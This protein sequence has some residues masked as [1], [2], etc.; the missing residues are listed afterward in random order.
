MRGITKNHEKQSS[1]DS[2]RVFS[3]LS[4]SVLSLSLLVVFIFS[5][6]L[7]S[8]SVSAYSASITTASSITVDITPSTTSNTSAVIKTEDINV[9][10][11]CR[12]GYNLTI[13][14]PSDR[15]LY[16]NGNSS[17]NTSGQYFSP[18]DG[19]STLIN[20]PNS[21]GYSLIANTESGIF[22]ALTNTEA[23]LKT[24]TQ[25]AS[26]S[27]I[28]DDFSIY[29]GVAMSN[30]MN[31]GSYTFSNSGTI[32]YQ[33]TTDSNCNGYTI[34]FDSNGGTGTMN[35]QNIRIEETTKIESNSFTAPAKGESYQDADGITITA[36]PN[37]LWAFWGWNTEVDG[38]GDWYKNGEEITDIA[39]D[40]ETI[41]LY[42]QW[43]Q[44]TLSDMAVTTS[45]TK[46]ITNNTMQDISPAIC[47]NSDIT[48]FSN[49]PAT[50]LTDNRDGVVK[51]YDVS[52]LADSNCWMTTN[53]ALGLDNDTVLLNSDNTDLEDGNTFILPAS[54][55]TD[56]TTSIVNA[57]R[58]TN[59]SGATSNGTYYS[60]GAA[61]T[62]NNYRSDTP[63]DSICPKNWDLPTNDQFKTLSSAS[64]YSSSYTNYTTRKPSSF[65][66]TGG[67]TLGATFYQVN[68]GHYW[69]ATSSSM[70]QAYG[71]KLSSS[72]L[73]TSQES[74]T[75]YGGNKFYRKNVR[76][77][78][79]QGRITINYDGN[80]S[81][82]RPVT[83]SMAKQENVEIS[84]TPVSNNSYERSGYQFKN[85][86]TERDGS[87]ID[88]DEG[89]LLSSVGLYDGQE[90]TLYAQWNPVYTITYVNN[91][92][93]FDSSGCDESTSDETFTQSIVMTDDPSTGTETGVLEA[94]NKWTSLTNKKIGSWNTSADGTGTDYIV[95][96]TFTVPSGSTFGDGIV[97]YAQ[98]VTTYT[99]VFDDNGADNGS[100]G[101]RND[102]GYTVKLTNVGEND[103][104]QLI[105]SNYYR[106]GYGFA[107]WSFYSS[108]TVGG[109]YT[110]YGPNA[111]IVTPNSTTLSALDNNN[112]GIIPLYA[113]WVPTVGTMQ[114]WSGCSNMSIG[115]VTALSDARDNDVYTIGKLVDGNCWMMENLRLDSADS[116]D[117]TLSQG[118]SGVFTG[119]ANSESFSTPSTTPNSLYTTDV[120]ATSMNIVIGGDQ[121]YRIPRYTTNSNTVSISYT[122]SYINSV[123]PFD[124]NNALPY[125]QMYL[126]GNKYNRAAI[127][128][129]TSENRTTSGAVSSSIC[130]SGW[131]LP[132]GGNTGDG[133]LSGGFYDL[134]YRLNNNVDISSAVAS[135]N[136]RA[137]PNNFV[138]TGASG[139]GA[140]GILYPEGTYW[141]STRRNTYSNYYFLITNNVIRHD[142]TGRSSEGHR[143]R[144]IK[145]TGLEIKLELNDGTNRIGGRVYGEAGSTVTLPTMS[146]D[147]YRFVDWNTA[148]DG[149][150]ISYA[151]AFIFD[152]SA[153]SGVTLYAQWTPI[154]TIQYDGNGADAGT[155]TNVRHTNTY[156]GDTFDLY[157]SNFSK[158]D[159]GFAGWS[160][161]SNAQPGGYSRIYG[162]NEEIEAPAASIPGEVK[163]LYA[164]WVP[165]AGN[166]QGWQGCPNM[167]IGDVTALKDMR[168]NNVYTVGKL[169]DEN[170]WMMENLR[171]NNTATGNSDG[172]LAQGYGGVFV[173]LAD[174]ETSNF[175]N[176]T[177]ANTLYSTDN[178]TG[179]NYRGYRFPRYNNANT[180]A[181][182][183][184]PSATDNRATATSSH[185]T[186]LSTFIYSYG[187]YYTW[188]AALANT[189][190]YNNPT[191][192]IDGKTS[193]TVNTSLCPSGWRLPY[194]RATGNGS[195]SGGFYYLN[196]KINNDSNVTNEVASRKIRTFPN[197]F[198]Y[199]GHI[200]SGSTSTKGSKGFYWSSTSGSGSSPYDLFFS[201]SSVSPGTYYDSKYYGNSIRCI[202]ES[203]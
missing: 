175:S 68:S 14:G 71:A 163:T 198:L 95:S 139:S 147:N 195:T 105:T 101:M 28:D 45:G 76:C 182:A 193:E 38:T 20:S 106:A 102:S 19:T 86:N 99:I 126:I 51:P 121:A 172:S 57:I 72:A 37:K 40:G 165:S 29:Y 91:C 80:G 66:A 96:S 116:G 134:N 174:P 17:N 111:D 140:T 52:K 8:S 82:L 125:I 3:N 12:A 146:R 161:D 152:A 144:C 137:Y 35:E 115:E 191:D 39:N 13:S 110:I 202:V 179:G 100:A 6:F 97:L 94:S 85:W 18:V 138:Y 50:T 47:Y 158:T 108:A 43:K 127:T 197:N 65:L 88:V 154:Y 181:R 132:Y 141:S 61:T 10:T 201:N 107:G 135:S 149:S 79:S 69:S 129:D 16:K 81:V 67:F 75:T 120:S 162:P 153:T 11:N 30:S 123:S 26:Q 89:V 54:T 196:Y 78:A 63:T 64:A 24:T 44:A 5:F 192:Q 74:G 151:D 157:A 156:E 103:K 46:T 31:P 186:N 1:E 177:R 160:F 22:T 109:N 166:I 142:D 7:N 117:N 4:F 184:N 155:M 55:I 33:L 2:R 90:V 58:T 41:T 53:L 167:D 36:D 145:A 32:V 168:D 77:V 189:N 60:W 199:S 23:Y 49:A 112:D 113:V 92:R 42:A 188:A 114:S 176:T 171:L 178:I 131:R 203:Q 187:N 183:T 84:Y 133:M 83:G 169:A 130:P 73:T 170:C 194:G 9:V 48:T 143:A 21:W 34:E 62:S 173:G 98:W 119:L 128:A 15:N 87:G 200:D 122:R 164:V 136:L 59:K 185:G 180:N 148:S 93:T 124:N 118:F 56:N 150:G 190:D 104:I 25:T 27:D 70:Y 159:Y